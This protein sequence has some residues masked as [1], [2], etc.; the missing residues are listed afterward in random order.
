MNNITEKISNRIKLLVS[1]V[2]GTFNAVALVTLC[3]FA[4]ILAGLVIKTRFVNNFD[5]D[6][7]VP[8]ETGFKASVENYFNKIS[9]FCSQS[10]SSF[11]QVGAVSAIVLLG[12]FA[13][14]KYKKSIDVP[15]LSIVYTYLIILPGTL[16][17]Y[18][19]NA[20]V[21]ILLILAAF[22]LIVILIP[23][24]VYLKLKND[25]VIFSKTK[26]GRIILWI[27]TFLGRFVPTSW[28][29]LAIS[30]FMMSLVSYYLYLNYEE[31]E[32]MFD[33]SV[34]PVWNWTIRFLKRFLDVL[35]YRTSKYSLRRLAWQG[36]KLQKA[37][38]LTESRN[39]WNPFG[40]LEE[41]AKALEPLFR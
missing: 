12:Y 10:K 5:K 3:L 4:V 30:S 38:T 7:A 16:G 39:I 25:L 28:T 36:E 41:K 27:K 2:G 23:D 33:S 34:R 37:L 17:K 29:S 13:Y 31:Y 8:A 22:C 18:L 32:E 11:L 9:L 19:N 14:K 40:N 26:P 1:S 35:L 6:L 21:R 20:T 15:K 24:W